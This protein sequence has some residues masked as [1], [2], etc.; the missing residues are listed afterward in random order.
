MGTTCSGCT[1]EEAGRSQGQFNFI[2]TN[3][4]GEQEPRRFKLDDYQTKFVPASFQ[5]LPSGEKDKLLSEVIR[6]II[7]HGDPGAISTKNKTMQ[8]FLKKSS[9]KI[10]NGKDVYEG[11]TIEGIAN[12]FGTVR[13]EGGGLFEGSFVS[14]LRRGR[15]ISH[16][17]NGFVVEAVYGISGAAQGLAAIRSPAQVTSQML[18]MNGIGFGPAFT[19]NPQDFVFDHLSFDA[20]DGLVIRLQKNHSSLVLQEYSK[21]SPTTMACFYTRTASSG[22]S[23]SLNTVPSAIEAASYKPA[24]AETAADGQPAN[25]EA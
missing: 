24:K 8:D 5:H 2:S 25:V 21:G 9:A 11:E 20:R 22:F 6:I 14:G 7:H 10:S 3:R 12:G 4:E 16:L 15:G 18:Y 1:D 23:E 13:L 17:P 19:E